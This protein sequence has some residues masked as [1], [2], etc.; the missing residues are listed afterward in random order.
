MID[1]GSF[2]KKL[3]RLHRRMLLLLPLAVIVLLLLQWLVRPSATGVALPP[4][5]QAASTAT[6][7]AAGE[8]AEAPVM[9]PR[10]AD[11]R[12][13]L[14]S[15]GLQFVQSAPVSANPVKPGPAP[16]VAP[17]VPAVPVEKPAAVANDK[18]AVAVAKTAVPQKQAAP[19]PA[20]TA[21][22][23]GLFANLPDDAWLLQIA[24]VSN[25]ADA[26]S[27]C[28][29]LALPCTSY[30]AS[31]Q[32]KRVW[33]LVA[34]PYSSREDAVNA[35]SRLPVEMRKGPFPRRVSD[36]RKDAAG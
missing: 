31:R 15:P 11:R 34:G 16:Q 6:D 35:A 22:R 29:Q 4:L 1:F 21:N 10:L 36:V 24:A 7:T 5:P 14:S 8:T 9:E 18:P 13:V 19:K 33:V 32:G 12:P 17:A 27:R 20:V 30:A 3:P 26:R 25:E 2:W 28:Q 23:K